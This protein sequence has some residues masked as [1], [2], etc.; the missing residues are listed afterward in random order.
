MDTASVK[1][2]PVQSDLGIQELG[3]ALQ[4]DFTN[5]K[6]K[7]LTPDVANSQANLLDVEKIAQEVADREKR[8]HNIV[9][10]VL[11]E[12]KDLKTNHDQLKTDK[13][14]LPKILS[15]VGFNANDLKFTR[16][17]KFDSSKQERCINVL[18]LNLFLITAIFQFLLTEYQSFR[19]IKLLK[20]N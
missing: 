16:L 12:D 18:S 11:R 19:F 8:K 14:A 2:A 6:S 7:M 3:P 4:N 5:L 9:I 13:V 1:S 17:S 20:M 10:F 15:A